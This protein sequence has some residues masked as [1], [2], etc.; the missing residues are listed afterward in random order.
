MFQQKWSNGWPYVGVLVAAVLLVVFESDLLYTLQE[1]NLFLH[2]PLFFQQQMMKAG[3][4]L[5]WMGCYLTQFFYYPMLGAFI[6]CL[7]WALLLWLLKRAFCLSDCWMALM[8]VGC[9][10]L[11]IATTGYW[12]Y[13]QKLCGAPF[14]ATIGSLVAVAQ[15]WLYRLLPRRYLLR[16]LFVPLS[17]CIGYPLFG[18]YGLWATALMALMAWRTA[19]SRRL[20][21]TLTALVAIVAVPLVCYHT[22]Y[23]ETNIVDI[24][25]TA[26]PVFAMHGEQYTAYYVPYIVLTVSIA[27]MAFLSTTRRWLQ[28]VV[29]TVVATGVAVF[30]YKDD[31]FHRELSMRRCLESLDYEQVLRI[32]K[33][34]K[35]EP[36]RAV[37]LMQ[38][39]ALFRTGRIEREVF[40][41]PNG[42]ARPAAPF[43]V[44]SVHTVGKMLYLQYGIPNY[45]YRWCMEDGVEYGW[46]VEELKLMAKCSLLN[47]EL[48]AAQRYLNMLK[49][50]DFHSSWAE[51]YE[52]FIH[53]P[54]RLSQDRELRDIIPLLRAD[55][56]L[57]ADQS[58]LEMF[59][60]EHILS[61]PG[62]TAMQ[63][64]LAR[65][66]MSFY[67]NCHFELIEP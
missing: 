41:Y 25:W 38:N 48:V 55:N 15:V 32:S 22:V 53:H 14:V 26:L 47:G 17:A 29:V 24:Y 65:F 21:D 66:T 19:G 45:C 58:Q 8:P 57:T 67:N 40:A 33:G 62:T 23:H 51:H 50:T 46:G 30:W 3:G 64:Q 36:T 39:L 42:A 27:L 9:L 7:L 54:Q 63:Q 34:V 12:V 59:L 18:F 2:S 49:K 16:S 35:G 61:T 5:T 1:Q 20:T 13:Y 4:L 56:F 52:A 37:C 10:L 43:S 11:S 6:L 60:I 28:G 44:R 31:N